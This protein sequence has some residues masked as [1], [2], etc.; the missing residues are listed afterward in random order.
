MRAKL[1]Y[2]ISLGWYWAMMNENRIKKEIRGGLA[3][4]SRK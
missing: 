3:G 2:V 4:A 1:E